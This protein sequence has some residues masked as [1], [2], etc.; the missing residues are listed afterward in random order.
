MIGENIQA[1]TG[2]VSHNH[3]DEST[4][5]I[6]KSNTENTANINMN[7]NHHNTAGN[8]TNVPQAPQYRSQNSQNYP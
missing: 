8:N 2:Q 4:R 6:I 1:Q 7:N 3:T 5:D